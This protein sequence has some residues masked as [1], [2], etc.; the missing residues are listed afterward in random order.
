[1]TVHP[2]V[3]RLTVH[4]EV[5]RITVHWEVERMTGNWEDDCPLGG[6]KDGCPLGGWEDGCPSLVGS[7]SLLLDSLL[8]ANCSFKDRLLSSDS[9]SEVIGEK[10]NQEESESNSRSGWSE[11]ESEGKSWL[12]SREG[13]HGALTVSYILKLNTHSMLKYSSNLPCRCHH[14][15]WGEYCPSIV[16]LQ[17]H[18]LCQQCQAI[19]SQIIF[20]I[21]SGIA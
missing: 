4:Q 6:R 12:I 11:S 16:W 21:T 17:E 13:N 14:L 2:D 19:G 18:S 9:S 3:E 5:K 7:S 1:M 20:M 8:L 10:L 15:M